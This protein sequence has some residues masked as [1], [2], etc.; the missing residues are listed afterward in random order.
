MQF[1]AGSFVGVTIWEYEKIRSKAVTA[2]RNANP[3]NWMKKKQKHLESAKTEL[4]VELNRI[5]NE[6][7]VLWS[8]LGPG[9]RI[10]VPIFV[11]NAIVYGLWRVP[12][13]KPFMLRY[14]CSNPAAKAVCWP[15]VLSTFSHYSL[16]HLFAN[17][18]VLHSFSAASFNLGREQFLG[19]YLSAGVISSF[20]SYLF[21]IA[22]ASPGYSLG[23]VSIISELYKLRN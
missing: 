21:K 9:E 5:Q 4:Q 14:F 17:M 1:T 7:D 22:T 10:F 6:I 16:F 2:L 18:Y 23:A 19:L 13:M 12:R 15:M 11:I 20:T 3:L 8:K